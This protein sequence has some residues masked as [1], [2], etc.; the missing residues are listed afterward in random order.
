MIHMRLKENSAR[1]TRMAM[2]LPKQLRAARA[3][4][5]WSREDLAEKAGV[6]PATVRG[7][8]LLGADSKQSTIFR[9]QR[10]LEIAGVEFIEGDEHKG[11]GVRLKAP[12]RRRIGPKR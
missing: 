5:G 8:E 12:D 10:A 6:S 3:L 4:V 11:P 9:M 2:L 7:F 1:H